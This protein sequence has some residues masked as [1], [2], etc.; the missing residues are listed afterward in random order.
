MVAGGLPEVVQ[1]ITTPNRRQA[2]T[3]PDPAA[4]AKTLAVAVLMLFWGGAS[5][6]VAA[7][8]ALQVPG[9][10]GASEAPP[11]LWVSVQIP[12]AGAERVWT[13]LE[14]EWAAH[15]RRLEGGGV[16]A[17]LRQTETRSVE[18]HFDTHDLELLRA[19]KGVRHVASRTSGS[20]SVREMVHAD[21][22]GGA[23]QLSAAGTEFGVQRYRRPAHLLDGH[24]LAG[25]IVREE[26]ELFVAL[27]EEIGLTPEMLFEKL[28][29]NERR[30]MLHVELDGDEYATLSVV[31]SE[32][33]LWGRSSQ[34]A[35]VELAPGAG[36]A[37]LRLEGVARDQLAGLAAA[38]EQA[39]AA[40]APGRTPLGSPPATLLYAGLEEQFVLLPL[41]L[42]YRLP[43][44]VLL[45]LTAFA[46]GTAALLWW[47]APRR[48]PMG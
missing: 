12:A 6:A 24:P 30:R 43:I 3:R 13:R 1:G 9:G 22:S 36:A 5:A 15:T 2:M 47:R 26:R 35:H 11:V 32:T 21:L 48:V 39:L 10:E 42:R 8:P 34:V 28:T 33:R 29:V 16:D 7:G 44:G 38:V 27:L 40:E 45:I 20:E 25:I 18:R 37:L 31:E 14:A 17:R 46:A 23:P 4:G 19:G 41:A